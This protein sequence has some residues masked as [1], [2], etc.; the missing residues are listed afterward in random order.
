MRST[1]VSRQRGRAVWMLIRRARAS[2]SLRSSADAT[3]LPSLTAL[4]A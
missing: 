4:S 3:A 1:A 2:A